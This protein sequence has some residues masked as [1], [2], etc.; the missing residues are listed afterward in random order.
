MRRFLFTSEAVSRGHPDKIADQISDA[1]LDACI[2]DDPNCRVA[3]E[4]LITDGLIVL[5][6]EITASVK[7]NYK[8]IARDVLYEIGYDDISFGLNVDTLQIL[9]SFHGQSLDIAS[10]IYQNQNLRA[11][12]QGMMF[13]FACLDTLEL[14]PLPILCAHHILKAVNEARE[15]KKLPYLGPDGK[16]QVTVE[17]ENDIPQ[18]IHTIV[19][20]TQHKKEIEVK[21][22]TEDLIKIIKT[23]PYARFIDINT[24]IYINPTGRF[25]IGNI[26]ADTGLTGRKIMVDTYGGMGRH[27]GGAFSGKDPSKVDRTGSYMARFIAKNI[28]HAKLAKRCEVQISYAIGKADP[29]SLY[30]E[31]FGEALISSDDLNHLVEKNFDLRPHAIIERLN[32]LRPIYKKTAYGGHFGREEEEFTWEYTDPNL[33]L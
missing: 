13:G 3:A 21:A 28:V 16:A 20:S 2:K 22:L 5:A 9:S 26:K 25:V 33:F 23:I 10:G 8:E 12:D 18:R 11:G 19:L 7:L 6:G 15:S 24:R 29:I 31:T 1:I 17:Y 4:T 14:M 32:L 27:G 30:V